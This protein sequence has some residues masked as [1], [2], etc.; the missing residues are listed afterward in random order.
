M[1]TKDQMEMVVAVFCYSPQSPNYSNAH[2]K[3]HEQIIYT[4]KTV[5]M[6]NPIMHNCMDK[7]HIVKNHKAVHELT[8]TATKT[9]QNR[10]VMSGYSREEEGEGCKGR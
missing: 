4:I 3:L 7:P 6:N 5:T 10:V 8:Y 1:P 2:Q 9:G